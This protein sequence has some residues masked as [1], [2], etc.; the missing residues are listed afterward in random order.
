[1]EVLSLTLILVCFLMSEI[2][3][4]AND[5]AVRVLF[6]G[7]SY[8]YADDIPWITQRLA[9]SAKTGKA[10]EVEMEGGAELTPTA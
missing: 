1:M 8:T 2:V 3:L 5:Q 7:N 4:G 6:V 10:L 9:K